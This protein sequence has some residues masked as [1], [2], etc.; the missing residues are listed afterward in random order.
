MTDSAILNVVAAAAL[1]AGVILAIAGLVNVAWRSASAAAR[2]LVWTVAVAAS[3]AV[4]ALTIALSQLDAP[5]IEVSAWTPAPA[6][7]LPSSFV[8]AVAAHPEPMATVAENSGPVSEPIAQL[9]SSEVSLHDASRP[10]IQV[11]ESAARPPFPSPAD[12]GALLLQLWIAGIVVALLPLIVAIVR[13]RSLARSARPARTLRWRALIAGTKPIAHLANRVRILESTETAMPMTWGILR[14]T[15]LVP[16][17]TDR[18]PD[19]QCRDILMHELAHIERR[20]CL[21]QLV[22]QIACAVYWFNPLAWIAA[23]R[24]KVERELACDDRVISAGSRASDYASN[25]LDVARSLRAPSL[26]SHT[27]IAMARPSQLS[28][29][30]LAVLDTRRNRRRVTRQIAAGT[31]FAA[32]VLVLPLASLTTASTATAHT[33]PAP[34]TSS[35]QITEAAQKPLPSFASLPV[36]IVRAVQLPAISVLSTGATESSTLTAKLATPALPEFV[37]Q[38]PTC[39]DGTDGNTNVSI[40]TDDDHGKRK[41]YSAKY[42]RDNCSLEIRAEG[43]FTLRADLSDVETIGRDGWVRIEERIGRSSRRVEIRRADNG[44]LEHQYWVNGDRATFDSN[45][46]AWL[47]RT[48]LGVERRTAFAADTRVPQLYR[49]G[50]L[51]AVLSEISQM[52]S[53][54]PKSKYYSTMLE[55]GIRLD[56]NTLNGIVRQVGTDLSSSDYYMSEVLGKFGAQS[57]A[58]ETTWRLFAETAGKMKSDYYKSQ[59]LKKVLSKGR[60]SASTVG[61][62]LRSASGM[63]SDYY[64]TELLKEVAGKYALSADTRQYY[65]EALRGIESDYYRSELLRT[66]GADGDWDARTTNLVLESAAAIK[67]DYYKSESLRALAQAK[68]VDNWPA[69]FSATST[70]ESDYYKKETLKS[71]LKHSPLTRE[72]VAGVINAASRIKSDSEMAEV[73]TAVA[74]TYKL[75]NSLRDAFEKAVDAMDSDYYRGAALSALRRSMA[76]T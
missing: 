36:S 32:A 2:H 33:A 48:L 3:L 27:A 50:G 29:R 53:A 25:L 61:T 60:L 42:S 13:V 17:K 8:Q 49:S 14:P 68:H 31:S 9:A 38:D 41:S 23:S 64:L 22:A 7:I 55:M 39:W 24:M 71:A 43:D 69:F 34:T 70:I 73:L 54:Y 11:L 74:R 63:K 75:D 35:P 58:D 66:L 57:S 76:Q 10:E 67:S 56:T 72:I 59:T 28:G 1:K 19:W 5:R 18:W 40:N 12:W 47:A 21:T 4:P 6:A 51:R 37:A 65:V 44:S 16:S 52:S 26:T 15:L 30:L 62:L 20:D 45:G 46:R